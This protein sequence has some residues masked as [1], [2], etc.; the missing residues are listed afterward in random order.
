MEVKI[1]TTKDK[2]GILAPLGMADPAV[3]FQV[4]SRDAKA[5]E[6]NPAMSIKIGS[7]DVDFSSSFA[8]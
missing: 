7:S 5:L 1:A 6:L 3:K 4:S 2:T 8:P